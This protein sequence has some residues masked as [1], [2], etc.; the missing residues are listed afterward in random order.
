MDKTIL[1]DL[2]KE[3]DNLDILRDELTRRQEEFNKTN[4]NLLKQIN[5][6]RDVISHC[7]E[8]I[9][10]T[11]LQ[12]FSVDGVKSRFGGIGIRV[13]KECIYDSKIA[14]EWAKKKDMFLQL[15][16]KGFEK[17][18]KTGEIDFVTL[19]DKVTVTFPSIIK[20]EE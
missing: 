10:E 15:D 11:T 9:T 1:I 2:K 20:L 3:T 14:L 16:T 7:K 19:Q 4:E 12:E 5:E 13:S 8:I 17:V 6:S 18:A